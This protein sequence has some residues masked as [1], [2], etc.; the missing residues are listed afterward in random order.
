MSVNI[1]ETAPVESNTSEVVD[2]QPE[3]VDAFDLDS[4]INTHF[5]DD[6]IMDE[7]TKEHKIGLPYEQ[8]LKHIPEN[9]RKV[10]QNLRASY[11][12]KTQELAEQRA[13]VEALREAMLKQ[14]RLMS[15]SEFARNISKLAQ[16]NTEHDIWDEDGRRAAIKK[17]AAQMM[18]E[19]LKPLQE[20][21][22]LERRSLELERFK[23]DHPDLS[24]L[25]LDIAKILTERKD[26]KLEDAYYIA[27]AKKDDRLSAEERAAKVAARQVSRDGLSK[28]STGKNID[29][30]SLKDPKFKSAWDAFQYHKSLGKK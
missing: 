23:K 13:E 29:S 10:I 3:A 28:T 15:D 18:Q 11:T 12:K 26:L 27:K 20:E 6:P 19:M 1:V 4:L 14:Q 30:G 24:D 16:D 8:V 7:P 2:V 9:G 21:V 22:A 17:E 25:R 5:N